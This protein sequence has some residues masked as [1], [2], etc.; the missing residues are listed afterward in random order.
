MKEKL[1]K[2]LV[3]LSHLLAALISKSASTL[4]SE[5]KAVYNETLK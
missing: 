3:S 2:G 4:L 5:T 1:T